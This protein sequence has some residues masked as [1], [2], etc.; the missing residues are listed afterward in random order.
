MSATL[1]QDQKT[2]LESQANAELE[3]HARRRTGYLELVTKQFSLVNGTDRTE[4]AIALGKT[5]SNSLNDERSI[6]TKKKL[7]EEFAKQVCGNYSDDKKLKPYIVLHH[8][9]LRIP[10]LK[11]LGLSWALKCVGAMGASLDWKS[12][13]DTMTALQIERAN[14]IL[15]MLID[16]TDGVGCNTDGKA[17]RI[18]WC[19]IVKHYLNHGTLPVT[20]P[21]ADTPA[22]EPTPE[23]PTTP[24]I[25]IATTIEAV[26]TILNDSSTNLD[27]LC[28]MLSQDTMDKLFDALASATTRKQEAAKQAA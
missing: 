12:I 11:Q 24:A 27:A 18:A 20:T 13:T 9:S 2:E 6:P 17:D 26:A 3:A 19:K 8:V 21:I 28:D 5:L 16:G 14:I 7:L 23:T 10:S 4:N 15:P 22:V 1:T 25:P